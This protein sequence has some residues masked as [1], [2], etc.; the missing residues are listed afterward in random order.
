MAELAQWARVSYPNVRHNT[1]WGD[2]V[3]RIG[4]PLPS[5]Y[6]A[7]VTN[8]G[9][10][11]FDSHLWLH[12]PRGDGEPYD[13]VRGVVEREGALRI[14]WQAGEEAPSWLDTRRDRLLA[15]ASTGDGEYI[16]WWSRGGEA[17][18]ERWPVVVQ[19]LDGEWEVFEV[20][21]SGFLLAWVRGELRTELISKTFAQFSNSF[22]QYDGSTIGG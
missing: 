21:S 17:E 10:G 7:M 8:F 1:D 11:S 3:R 4:A 13:L 5:D 6:R 20:T 18:A 9:G 19:S 2:V 15:W 12:A 22:I 14:L 16:Y